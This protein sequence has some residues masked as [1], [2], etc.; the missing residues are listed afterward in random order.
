[1]LRSFDDSFPAAYVSQEEREK[2]VDEGSSW[3]SQRGTQLSSKKT[4]KEAKRE[5]EKI[6]DSQVHTCM[7]HSTH[8]PF[9]LFL[10]LSV[11]SFFFTAYFS[12]LIMLTL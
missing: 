12:F 4:T 3:V 7:Q 8:L 9:L 5:E 1:M 10:S 6:K 11:A 2:C